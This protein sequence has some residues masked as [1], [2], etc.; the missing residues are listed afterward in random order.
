M[1]LRG[2]WW[3]RPAPRGAIIISHGFAEHGGCY[4]RVA[5]AFGARLEVDVIAVDYRG[6]G[7]SPGRRGVVRRFDDLVGDLASVVEWTRRQLPDVPRFL[8]AHSNGGQVALRFV[9]DGNSSI[10]VMVVANP[11]VRVS[12]P[13][14]PSKLRLGRFLGMVAPWMTL[15]GDSRTDVLTRD[16]EIQEEH[17]ADPL[18]HN[19]MSPPLFFGMVAGGE[20]LMARAAE[21]RVPLL[22]VLGGQDTVIDPGTSRE[23]FDRLGSDDKTLLFYPKMLHEPLNDLGREQVIEDMVR[24]LEPRLPS[25]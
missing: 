18:R 15:R 24:W 25:R 11:A 7:R 8:L 2:R 22:M 13:I 12:V 20:M 19:R 17:R 5:E 6:H 3:R 16:P 23:F 10:D 14:S 1:V 4:R 21:I 9:L